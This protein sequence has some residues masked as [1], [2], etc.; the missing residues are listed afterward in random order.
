[1][2]SRAS[3][4]MKRNYRFQKII[5][6]VGALL[7]IA[8]FVAYFITGSVSIL[9]DALESIVNVIAGLIGLYALY[10]T[11]Q[12]PDRD[13]PY[14][15]GK[16]ELI[17]SSVEGTMIC[18]A[19]VLIVL[20]TV[21]RLVQ[22]DYEIRSLDLGLIIVAFAAAV[23]FAMGMTAVRMGRRSHSI[24]LEASGKHLCSDTYSSVGILIGLACVYACDSVGIDAT[25]IDP[26]MALLFGFVIMFTGVRVVHRSI[27]GIMDRSDRKLLTVVTRGLN[28]A[29]TD[30]VLDIHHLRVTRYGAALHIDAHMVVR[31]V[32][33]V[34]EAEV[35]VTRFRSEVTRMLGG[36]LDI[37]FMAEPCERRFC[38]YCKCGC[39][40]RRFDFV[41]TNIITLDKATRESPK[42]SSLYRDDI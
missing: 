8:K 1:M 38:R 37:T 20:E 40:E 17:S 36:D 29:R 14:G 25:W 42:R 7:M 10:L 12:P 33:T 5:A 32:L 30:D 18:A 19:G 27:N 23:N 3:P 28:H 9:T 21:V 26:A 35:I 16:V 6:A 15:H 22:G 4:Q 41:E 39:T 13:H 2:N 11:M 24:A 31:Q 34:K